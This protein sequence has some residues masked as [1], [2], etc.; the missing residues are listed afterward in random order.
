MVGLTW[1]WR[2]YWP[3]W[4][5]LGAIAFAGF[6]SAVAMAPLRSLDPPLLGLLLTAAVG[7]LVYA[8]ALYAL[9]PGKL[10]RR[11][12]ARLRSKFAVAAAQPKTVVGS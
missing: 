6:C 1:R 9:D 3:R 8:V 4:R 5:D 11:N 10:I 2:A 12:L 7:T